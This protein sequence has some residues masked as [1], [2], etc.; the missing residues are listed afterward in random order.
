MKE[1]PTIEM[2]AGT[3]VEELSRDEL[4]V[5]L[6]HCIGELAMYR[7]PQAMRTQS[8]GSVEMLKRG[9]RILG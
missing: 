3:P 4:L 9:E 2:W 7:T 1:Y 5:A 6:K 8:L